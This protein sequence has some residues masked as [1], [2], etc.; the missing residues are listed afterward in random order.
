MILGAYIY[1]ECEFL[2]FIPL[3]THTFW[4]KIAAENSCKLRLVGGEFFNEKPPLPQI[5]GCQCQIEDREV[6]PDREVNPGRFWLRP[7]VLVE[8]DHN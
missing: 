2:Y 8:L 4:K 5:S 6:C 3:G 1:D 7:S